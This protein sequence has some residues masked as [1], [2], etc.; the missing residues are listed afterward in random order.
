MKI[1]RC[2]FTSPENLGLRR[3]P[4][5]ATLFH[6]NS[7]ADARQVKRE[8]SPHYMSL[9]G[10]W[11][12]SYTED[13]C[14]ISEDIFAEFYQAKKDFYTDYVVSPRIHSE[15]LSKYR[16]EIKAILGNEN[17][18]NSPKEIWAYIKDNCK[19]YENEE[20]RLVAPVGGYFDHR[21]FR[22]PCYGRGRN[23]LLCQG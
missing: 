7:E 11:K 18:F 12:F 19:Y 13:P 16:S 22:Y 10:E 8:Y 1:E 3:E 4:A 6:F 9:D 15:K 23:G 20:V 17:P 14:S 5:A 21:N 2:F